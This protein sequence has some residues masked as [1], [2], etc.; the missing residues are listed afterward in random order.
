MFRV[1]IM[2]RELRVCSMV[3]VESVGNDD[4]MSFICRLI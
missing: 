4:V 2:V 3:G 1:F